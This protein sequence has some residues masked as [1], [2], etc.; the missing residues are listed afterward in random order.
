MIFLIM[1]CIATSLSEVCHRKYLA[2]MT[3][4]I[5]LNVD[6]I[7]LDIAGLLL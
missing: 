3:D 7:V 6:D 5:T 2:L 4:D 1:M